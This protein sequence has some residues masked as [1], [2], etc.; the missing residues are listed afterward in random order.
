MDKALMAVCLI[1]VVAYSLLAA[2]L[3]ANSYFYMSHGRTR[4]PRLITAI[5]VPMPDMVF[6][7]NSNGNTLDETGTCGSG[8]SIFD[9]FSMTC[10]NLAAGSTL[11]P[12]PAPLG[13]CRWFVSPSGS[14]S[15]NG[16]IG[17]PW[18][19]KRLFGG[20]PGFGGVGPPAAIHPGDNICMRAGTYTG[21]F[22]TIL[23]GSN[24]NQITIQPYPGERVIVDSA[25]AATGTIYS[26]LIIGSEGNQFGYVTL[27]DLEITD[28]YS[29]NRQDARPDGV[30]IKAPGVKLIN[31]IIHDVGNGIFHNTSANDSELY[32]NVIYN[33]GWD[34]RTNGLMQGGTGHGLYAA[35]S[36]GFLRVYH[37]IIATSLGY[38]FHFY[39]AGGGELKNLDVQDN[40]SLNNG[41]WTRYHDSSYATEGRGTDNYLIGHRPISGAVFT[42]NFGYHREQRGTQN[43]ELGYSGVENVSGTVT[44]NVFVNGINT[45]DH[46]PSLTF[47]GNYI[48]SFFEVLQFIAANRPIS[49]TINNNT[50]YYYRTECPPQFG[51]TANDTPT[52]VAQWKAL[53]FDANSTIHACGVR[54]ATAAVTIN[55]NTY[56]ANR[57]TVIVNNPASRAT[58]TLNLSSALANGDT[59]ELHNAQDYY[60][61]LVASGTYNGPISINMT[62]L[63]VA[64][65][66]AHGSM[67]NSTPLAQMTSGPQFGA[68]ILI[69]K[70]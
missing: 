58:V 51:L 37:N 16:S 45:I 69:K 14:F 31:N 6:S 30:Y 34:D 54:D 17:S 28:S 10:N 32:G 48:S 36:S 3:P 68:F 44:N 67:P 24:G 47:T 70:T 39:S 25:T 64:T 52:T 12:T 53:G 38:G 26:G 9:Y 15:G 23:A 21:I 41:Y 18:S 22:Q 40:V 63:K 1:S 20:D 27:R 5:T 42:R 33:V 4:I 7:D 49:T 35:N 13:P 61:P 43:F 55:P 11:T 50:Y 8:E 19:L 29:A 57:Y 60:G 62:T 56:D 66:V 65:P 59:F 2:D 46:F